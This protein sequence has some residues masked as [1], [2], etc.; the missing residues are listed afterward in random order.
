MSCILSEPGGLLSAAG[1][2]TRISCA[3]LLPCDC[4]GFKSPPPGR[5]RTWTASN[6]HCTGGCSVAALGGKSPCIT[7]LFA[8][9][10][11][12]VSS[13]LLMAEGS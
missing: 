7:E 10:P 5:P 1:M 9:H 4:L 6:A 3:V 12:L 2:R 11:S 8:S 13:V